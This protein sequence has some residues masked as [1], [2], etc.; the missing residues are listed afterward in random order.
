MP[1][2]NVEDVRRYDW[3]E[4]NGDQLSV[5]NRQLVP[6]HTHILIQVK[7]SPLSLR[8]LLSSHEFL[9]LIF[10]VQKLLIHPFGKV[11]SS[12]T[13]FPMSNPWLTPRRASALSPP[14]HAAGYD[15]NPIPPLPPDPPD[16]GQY[17]PLSPSSTKTILARNFP[18]KLLFLLKELLLLLLA[19]LQL[20]QLI[21]LRLLDLK[22][23]LVQLHM[24]LRRQLPNIS[25]F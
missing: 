23:K 16:L 13:Q 21:C 3:R 20:S 4:P 8:S 9:E 14:S 10:A 19:L 2:P 18:P 7:T 1:S 17:P 15:R 22:E 11:K 12:L 25:L 6:S 5:Q 24:D